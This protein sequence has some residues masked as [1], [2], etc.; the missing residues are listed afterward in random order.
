MSY[1][2]RC[3]SSPYTTIRLHQKGYTLYNFFYFLKVLNKQ[4]DEAG[5]SDGYGSRVKYLEKLNFETGALKGMME[6]VL[7]SWENID[8]GKNMSS[9]YYH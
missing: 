6:I 2:M 9:N 3:E 7:E 4:V 1:F 8:K 5:N